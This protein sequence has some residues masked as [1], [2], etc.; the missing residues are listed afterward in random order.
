[1]RVDGWPARDDQGRYLYDCTKIEAR[2]AYLLKPRDST[3]SEFGELGED[4]TPELLRDCLDMDKIEADC[5][6]AES[7]ITYFDPD[8]GAVTM[9][10]GQ[11]EPGLYNEDDYPDSDWPE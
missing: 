10:W 11:K 4:F 7:Y 1:L 2:G 3:T 5:D 6:P 8:T 9:L